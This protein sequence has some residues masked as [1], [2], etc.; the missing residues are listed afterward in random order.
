MEKVERASCERRSTRLAPLPWP[1]TTYADSLQET[2]ANVE[3]IVVKVL[4]R[5]SS[6]TVV[7]EGPLDSGENTHTH[8]HTHTHA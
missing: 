5:D 3:D 7:A 1:G 6:E 4:K 8:T 2:V